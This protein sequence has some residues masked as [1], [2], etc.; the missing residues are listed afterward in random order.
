M[1]FIVWEHTFL[2]CAWGFPESAQEVFLK[3]LKGISGKCLRGFP[4]SALGDFRK[5]PKGVF[6]KSLLSLRGASPK[7]S[8]HHSEGFF[9]WAAQQLASQRAA[10]NAHAELRTTSELLFGGLYT[11]QWILQFSL[12]TISTFS[13]LSPQSTSSSEKP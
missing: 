13:T 5:A 6:E 9:F 12:R 10:V 4:V 7:Q 11:V 1:L 3:V 8:I 2:F